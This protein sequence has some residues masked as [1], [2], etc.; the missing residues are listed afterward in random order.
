MTRRSGEQQTH[1]RTYANGSINFATVTRHRPT[2]RTA[3]RESRPRTSANSSPLQKLTNMSPVRPTMQP[4]EWNTRK[5][6]PRA[7]QTTRKV[8]EGAQ[9]A[10]AKGGAQPYRGWKHPGN[11]TR[12]AGQPSSDLRL[13]GQQ[14]SRDPG[15]ATTVTT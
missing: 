12:N 2:T 7:R 9:T 1:R 13:I 14:T 4:G 15:A 10:A 8:S 11:A 3:V 5:I 6:D